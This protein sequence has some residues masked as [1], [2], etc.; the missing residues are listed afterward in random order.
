MPYLDV[1]VQIENQS[2]GY[3]SSLDLSPHINLE[4]NLHYARN[5]PLPG[6][7]IDLYT[8]T[9]TVSSA[10]RAQNSPVKSVADLHA[11]KDW[12]QA[13]GLQLFE[14]AVFRYRDVAFAQIAD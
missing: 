5:A 4:N 14:P 6:E 3:Q 12:E 9:F 8:L 10:M 11:S 2:S 1:R 13:H 7:N